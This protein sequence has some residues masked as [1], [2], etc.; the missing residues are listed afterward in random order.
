VTVELNL[1]F[2][3]INQVIVKFDDVETDTLDFSSP[4]SEEDQKDIQWY[5]E[6][7]ATRYTTE[8]DDERA[9]KIADQ[10]PKWGTDLFNAVFH[11]RAAQR[12]FNDFQDEDE[13]GR[14][15]TISASHPG[16]LSLPWELL[17]DPEGTFLVHE[18]PRISIRRRLAGAGGGR[19]AFKVQ[20]K[21]CLR[22]LF[23]VSRPSDR[24]F[25][26]PRGEAIAV[27]DA[28]T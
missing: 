27:L 1:R 28:I 8:V 18:N 17:R 12:L 2:P 6:V 25:I 20:V 11:S 21:D 14:L 4:I 26:D 23:V 22:L 9:K 5:L 7:Y 19:K 15:L 24:G 10:L 3:Q 16:I 13:P